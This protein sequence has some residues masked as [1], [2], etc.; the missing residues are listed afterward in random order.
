MR[1]LTRRYTELRPAGTASV[2]RRLVADAARGTSR[3][4]S[5]MT[6]IRRRK[7]ARRDVWFIDYRDATGARRHLTAPTREVAEDLLAPFPH[8]SKDPELEMWKKVG[9][10]GW[11]R[12]SDILINS[13]ALY[14]LSYRGVSVAEVPDNNRF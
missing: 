1:C 7:R 11:T 14:R 5:L 3:C 10:P 13:Q 4:H 9:S 8:V 12:T 6:S 2:R